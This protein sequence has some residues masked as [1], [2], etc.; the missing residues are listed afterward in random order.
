[1]KKILLLLLCSIGAVAQN[2]NPQPSYEQTMR[3]WH[4]S[5]WLSFDGSSATSFPEKISGKNFSN[6]YNLSFATQAGPI[7]TGWALVQPQPLLRV[8]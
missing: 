1:M 3:Y 6:E 2:P 5:V 4:P 7:G 8:R